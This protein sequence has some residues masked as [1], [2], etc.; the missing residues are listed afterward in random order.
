MNARRGWSQNGRWR[1]FGGRAS[2]WASN[3]GGPSGGPSGPQKKDD[4]NLEIYI[5]IGLTESGPKKPKTE[6]EKDLAVSNL[7]TLQ[8]SN[9]P[10]PCSD[11][12]KP[13][14]LEWRKGRIGGHAVCTIMGCNPYQTLP[15]LFALMSGGIAEPH[16]ADKLEF[17][18]WRSA[19]E[20]PIAQRLAKRAGYKLRRT[21]STVHADNPYLSASPDREIYGDP[22]GLGS[23]EI[24]SSDPNA[25][26]MILLKGAPPEFWVQN[27]WYMALRNQS[28]GA[29][30]I[31]NCSS[32]ELL[33]FEYEADLDFQKEMMN[34]VLEF[35]AMVERGECPKFDRPDAPRVPKVGGELVEVETLDARLVAEFKDAAHHF[36]IAK[37]I[38]READELHENVKSLVQNWMLENEIDVAD[39]FGYRFFYKEQAGRASFDK[40]QLKLD[41]P[42]ID[43]SKYEGRGD[44]FRTMKPYREDDRGKLIHL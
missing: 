24:K 14:W 8:I 2:R 15:E 32:G 23:A 40:K 26:R 18:E 20:E 5:G 13:E 42:E 37:K 6:N 36:E 12:Q 1:A 30:G 3:R 11:T 38:K 16:S 28:F 19:L 44:P 41:F 17:F 29:V 27:Q 21:L 35:L 33:H 25:F 43:F 9:G 39:G 31:G 34:R 10:V 22:R 4:K 7:P